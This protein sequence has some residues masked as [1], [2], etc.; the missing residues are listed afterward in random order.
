MYIRQCSSARSFALAHARRTIVPAG[1]SPRVFA[2]ERPV[3]R[4]LV[5]AVL[6]D[7]AHHVLAGRRHLP[8]HAVP[9]VTNRPPDCFGYC[10]GVGCV[11]NPCKMN[12]FPRNVFKPNGEFL[13]FSRSGLACF[14]P[15]SGFQPE[16]GTSV[17]CA[18]TCLNYRCSAG[19]LVSRPAT[20]VCPTQSCNL[21]TLCCRPAPAPLV[22]TCE[23]S[24]F[25]EGEFF[26]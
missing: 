4:V 23:T 17:C 14:T 25:G 11:T 19:V 5:E 24:F 6:P 3:H 22:T 1:D 12:V 10:L 9:Q 20:V 2:F 7:S 15:G 16:C 26:P 21:E 13:R 8:R 18:Q